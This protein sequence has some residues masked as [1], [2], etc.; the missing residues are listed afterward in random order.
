[1]LWREPGQLI[2]LVV[3]PL[4]SVIVLTVLRVQGR[5]DLNGI[6]LVVPTLTTMWSLALLVS[7]EVIA[8]DRWAGI[9]ELRL[10]A[11]AS[12]AAS[13]TGRVATVAAVGLLALVESWVVAAL[14]SG[15]TLS[16]SD[17]SSF[18]AST[19]L[20]D[21]GSVGAGLLFATMVLLTRAART[22]QNSL[23]YPFYV[24]GGLVVPIDQFPLWIR[25]VGRVLFL[26]W[27]ADLMRDSLTGH[28]EDAL[29]RLGVLSV[30]AIGTVIAGV[31]VVTKAIARL[32]RDGTAA[33]A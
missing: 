30:L 12:P 31:Y 17:G 33:L 18:V 19:V 25:L 20:A 13:I 7:A 23:S 3:A 6:A 29:A 9:L 1:M 26:S 21:V 27:S 8:D 22:L 10:A 11:P 28:P 4:L 16:I 15:H 24:L 2:Q 14:V 5:A 32:R